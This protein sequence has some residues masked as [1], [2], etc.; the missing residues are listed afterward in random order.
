MLF[1][2]EMPDYFNQN[3]SAGPDRRIGLPDAQLEHQP[4]VG[5]QRHRTA[6][7]PQWLDSPAD[8]DRDADDPAL[9]RLSRPGVRPLQNGGVVRMD[10]TIRLSRKPDLDARPLGLLSERGHPKGHT[11]STLRGASTQVP[12]D[13]RQE[14]GEPLGALQRHFESS[15]RSPKSVTKDST[16]TWIPAPTPVR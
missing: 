9:R 6:A 14:P 11:T 8:A 4:P 15:P 10:N 13:V 7:A 16:S 2:N 5:R 12:S 3:C 1:W